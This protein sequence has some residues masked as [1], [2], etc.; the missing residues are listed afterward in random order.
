MQVVLV[1][2]SEHVAHA[3]FSDLKLFSDSDFLLRVCFYMHRLVDQPD[4]TT[5][6]IFDAFYLL[7][8]DVVDVVHCH[9]VVQKLKPCF[10]HFSSYSLQC[11]SVLCLLWSLGLSFI[12]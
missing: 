4:L 9:H 11:S 1:Q 3:L 2:H 6:I 12:N 8:D 10:A 5:S 7:F